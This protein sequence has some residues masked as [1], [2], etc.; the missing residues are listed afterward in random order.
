[1][2]FLLA[3]GSGC[4]GGSGTGSDGFADAAG[5]TGDD[6]G[7]D[8]GVDAGRDAGFDAGS[9][10]GTDAGPDG[11]GGGR[12]D[13]AP[14]ESFLLHIPPG[15][16]LCNVFCEGRT[17]Q[18]ELRM[19]GRIDLVPGSYVLPRVEQPLDMELIQRVVFGPDRQPLDPSGP[20]SVDVAYYYGAWQYVFRQEFSRQGEPFRLE[21]WIW[22]EPSYWGPQWPPEV[23][24]EGELAGSW[25]WAFA[26]IG[27]GEQWCEERQGFSFC[28]LSSMPGVENLGTVE[29]GDRVRAEVRHAQGCQVAG[30]TTCEEIDLAELS[31]GGVVRAV[32]DPLDLIYSAEHHNFGK[33]YLLLLD[34]PVGQVAAVL[35]EAPDMGATEGGALVTLDADLTAT[36]SRP[37]T[38]WQVSYR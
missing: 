3:G 12:P 5:D 37:F 26:T 28:D 2:L 9:D 14:S 22:F 35:V 34:Q 13:S 36:D 18:D 8:A 17:W 38:N 31:L 7:D 10:P 6:A 24:L 19:I 25:S 29:N 15:A 33:K 21:V 30:N 4:S 27:P 16:G 23:T 11:D 20:G 1:L 32:T